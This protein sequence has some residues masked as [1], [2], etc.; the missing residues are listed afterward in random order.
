MIQGPNGCAELIAD[1]IYKSIKSVD[2]YNIPVGPY[3]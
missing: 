2:I 3:E 1:R